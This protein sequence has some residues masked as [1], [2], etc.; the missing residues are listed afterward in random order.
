[1]RA[2]T[3]VAIVILLALS[4]GRTGSAEEESCREEKTD[5][6]AACPG[7]G[8][9]SSE[10]MRKADS[11]LSGLTLEPVSYTHLTLP[12]NSRVYVSGVGGGL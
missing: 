5:S 8:D 1:M 3:V 10:A 6:V 12:T 11:V 9:L 4:C 7:A 2:W